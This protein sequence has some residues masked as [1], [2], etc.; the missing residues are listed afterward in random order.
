MTP[1]PVC[2]AMQDDESISS[3]LIRCALENGCDPLILTSVIWPGWRVWTTD[4]DRGIPDERQEAIAFA[5]GVKLQVIQQAAL[6]HEIRLL[7]PTDLPKHGVW[8]WVQG[9]GSRNRKYR[10][11][12]QYCPCCISED[13]KPYFRRHWRFSWS[14]G[15]LR[16]N[17]RLLDYCHQCLSPIEPQRL[18]AMQSVHLSDC[19]SCGFDLRHSSSE[20]ALQNAQQFQHRAFSTMS[21]AM[22]E[23]AGI[24]VPVDDWFKACR[25]LIGLIRRSANFPGSILATSLNESG[26][27]TRSI[28]PES[29]NLQFELLPAS[30]RENLLACLEQLLCNLKLLA[31]NLEER[32]A[33]ASSVWGRGRSLPTALSLLTE[34]LDQI[35]RPQINKRQKITGKPRSTATVLKSWARLKRK[36]GIQ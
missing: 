10:G 34:Q 11:G 22:G 24:P 25:H 32:G 1:W 16:H 19:A 2:V 7:S 21:H 36:Y 3:W 14:T 35:E 4:I 17:T 15:C 30:V 28:A 31:T 5:S 29:L 13:A 9:L 6:S 18:E 27:D 33:L 20:R 26:V 23:I 12:L 8:P